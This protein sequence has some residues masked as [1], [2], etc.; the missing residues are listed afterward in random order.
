[1]AS[2]TMTASILLG[3][4]STEGSI[5]WFANHDSIYSAQVLA[6]AEQLCYERLRIREM[7]QHADLSVA[8]GA[9]TVD[10][11]TLAPRFVQPIQLKLDGYGKLT[12]KR[13]EDFPDDRDADGALETGPV[14]SY[15]TVRGST[16]HF[17]IQL[18]AA[19]SG[20]FYYYAGLA[21]LATTSNETNALTDR[22]PAL[23][24]HAVMSR[25]YAHRNRADMMQA[26][27]ILFEQQVA[28]ANAHNDDHRY[29][30]EL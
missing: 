10:L 29:G 13:K 4:K 11:D 30:Q 6:E 2:T 1:M 7:E 8:S 27:L 18:N 28:L 14:P 23:L 9:S 24:R 25:A 20:D 3:T 15:W 12:Y 16:L 22:F 21:P 26:E 5:K 17:D 19:I